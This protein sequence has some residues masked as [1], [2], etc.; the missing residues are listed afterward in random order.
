MAARRDLIP[1]AIAA[2]LLAARRFWIAVQTMLRLTMAEHAGDEDLPSGLRE[3]LCRAVGV[4]D[5]A[6]LKQQMESMAEKT[7]SA[8]SIVIDGPAA[9]L[10]QL[11][12]SP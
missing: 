1:A 8:F 11:E 4:V 3:K 12:E 10:P 6:A 7:A 2:D 5:F 9:A